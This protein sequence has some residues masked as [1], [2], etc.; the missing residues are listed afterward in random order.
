MYKY[1]VMDMYLLLLRWLHIETMFAVAQRQWTYIY[2]NQG[3]ELHCLK[4]LDQTLRME[5]L[6]YHFL[7]AAGVRGMFY[8]LCME[9]VFV[10]VAVCIPRSYI[11]FCIVKASNNITFPG[12]KITRG[13]WALGPYLEARAP[14]STVLGARQ[15]LKHRI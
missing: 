12:V 2:D 8:I 5:F 15:G 1:I 13:P 4:T 10:V 3:I 14:R 11:D 9:N 7:L 6:P